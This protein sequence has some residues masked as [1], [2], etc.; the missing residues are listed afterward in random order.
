MN[1]IYNARQHIRNKILYSCMPNQAY[2]GAAPYY[3]MLLHPMN[4]YNPLMSLFVQ[5]GSLHPAGLN[6]WELGREPVS[7]AEDNY[8]G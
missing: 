3:H 7:E 2:P 4:D 6:N 1:N 8:S 5:Y